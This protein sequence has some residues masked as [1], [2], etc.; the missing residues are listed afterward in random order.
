VPGSPIS[1]FITLANTVK[2]VFTLKS[3]KEARLFKVQE[4][5]QSFYT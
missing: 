2:A 1:L 5:N 3:K 4:A